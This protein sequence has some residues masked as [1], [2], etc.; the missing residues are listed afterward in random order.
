M[1]KIGFVDYY[2]SEWHANNYPEWIKNAAS[3]LGAEYEV[4]YAWAEVDLSPVYN[5]TTDEWCA[6]MGV[7]KCETIAELNDKYG[8]Y[9][10]PAPAVGDNL[11]SKYT[12]ECDKALDQFNKATSENNVYAAMSMI[13]Q[14]ITYLNLALA[15][16]LAI[17]A[18]HWY[19][20]KAMADLNE[21]NRHRTPDHETVMA[22]GGVKTSAGVLS[23]ILGG[24]GQVLLTAL[25]IV[26]FILPVLQ[27]IIEI[28]L[29]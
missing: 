16:T 20:K 5:E 25:V 26:P 11:N 18:D 7:E 10:I 15:I 28:I 29:K 4:A 23:G 17:F 2:I 27:S 6:K 9:N 22:A 3:K 21:L 13:T 12:A 8:Y 14:A 24:L 1:K 19:Y